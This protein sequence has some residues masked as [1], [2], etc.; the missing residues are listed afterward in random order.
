MRRQRKRARVHHDVDGIARLIIENIG[1]G[2]GIA[3]VVDQLREAGH[4]D[5]VGGIQVQ[6][7]RSTTIAQLHRRHIGGLGEADNC[8]AGES[9]VAGENQ[10]AVAGDVQ[11]I[12]AGNGSID[13]RNSTGGDGDRTGADNRVIIGAA[14]Y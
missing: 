1:H 11:T 2:H 14:R 8:R 10:L 12:C 5:V 6:I 3:A 9:I 13:G 7:A 4:P